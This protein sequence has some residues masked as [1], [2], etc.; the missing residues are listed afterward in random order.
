MAEALPPEIKDRE[1]DAKLGS[2]KEK[3]TIV[4]VGRSKAGKSSLLNNVFR[5][6]IKKNNLSEAPGTTQLH[7]HEVSRGGITLCIVDTI[8]L[9]QDKREKKQQL[10]ELATYTENNADLVIFCIPVGPD[11]RFENNNPQLMRALHKCY[12]QNIWR[13][14]LVVFTFSNHVWDCV[15]KDAEATRQ[16]TDYITSYTAHFKEELK[17]M[18]VAKKITDSV[19]C[20]FDMDE[21]QDRPTLVTI[22]AG[23]DDE[24]PILPGIELDEEKWV[25][26]L[27]EEMLL[28]T[29]NE[30]KRALLEFRYTR[31]VVK[32]AFRHAYNEITNSTLMQAIVTVRRYRATV[33]TQT[34]TEP[35]H[36]TSNY[37]T[38]FT[39]T[40][41]PTATEADMTCELP[42]SRPPTRSIPATQPPTT[43]TISI[44]P[45]HPEARKFLECLSNDRLKA[46]G[47]CLGLRYVHLKNMKEDCLL[48][49]MLV[50]W[51]REDDD[52]K[53]T[54]GH[55]SWPSLVK[56]LEEAGHNGVATQIKEGMKDN[57]IWY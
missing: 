6:E 36:D 24:D 39:Q 51:L 52:V 31:E 20:I 28:S 11:T 2:C 49:E 15:K 46:I 25:G 37:S 26:K 34:S 30:S 41:V 33:A 57:I 7:T 12:G 22:P 38:S 21:D 43:R 55:P 5:L 29:S 56:A 53:E 47:V 27:F 4:V 40:F 10:R 50:S 42:P 19:K 44:A 1:I 16:Y 54:S 13:N 18:Q 32:Q 48:D 9:V 3:V 14:C 23:Y 35:P 45:K 8:G 17:K